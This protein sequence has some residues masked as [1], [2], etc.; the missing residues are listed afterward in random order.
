MRKAIKDFPKQFEWKPIIEN[1][2]E[3]TRLKKFIVLGMGGSNLTAGL[4][5]IYDP[6]LDVVVHKD[7]G[8]PALDG[9]EL[10]GRLTIAASYSGNTEE[11]IDGFLQALKRKLP[12]IALATGGTL[13]ALAQKHRV[14]YIKIP[15]TGIQPRMALGFT[16][17]ALLAIIGN[18][19]AIQAAKALS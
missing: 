3:L 1:A 2:D 11:T 7:Y 4:L 5:K 10:R 19:R 9:K 15:S 8:L 6:L 18:T 13:L 12:L 16:T 14:P 17:N